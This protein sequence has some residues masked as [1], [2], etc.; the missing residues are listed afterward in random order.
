[1]LTICQMS[2]EKIKPKRRKAR[3]HSGKQIRQI[4][5][6]VT[7]FGFVN[8]ILIDEEGSIIAGEGRYA[9]AKSLGLKEVPV[10]E[11]RGLSRAKRRALVLA[12]NKIAENAG[13][14]RKL[15]A[16]EL[17]ELAKV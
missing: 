15:L 6:S 10:I 11:L 3:T 16:I 5:D 8:P 14:D 2:I 12:D 4:A 13:W 9:A 7:T 17:P 1:M